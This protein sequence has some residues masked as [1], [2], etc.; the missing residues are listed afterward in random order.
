MKV[1]AKI[2]SG[3]L[4]RELVGTVVFDGRAVKVLKG[5]D[6]MLVRILKQGLVGPACKLLYPKDGMAFMDALEM[7]FTGT[8]RGCAL[9][10]ED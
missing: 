6:P 4:E 9:T 7:R 10:V 5:S 8:G 1:T 2:Y 3:M